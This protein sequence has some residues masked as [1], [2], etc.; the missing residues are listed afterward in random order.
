MGAAVFDGRG[1]LIEAFFAA[2]SQ[3]RRRFASGEARGVH[4]LPI[5]RPLQLFLAIKAMPPLRLHVHPDRLAK[6]AR[7]GWGRKAEP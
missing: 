6:G 2:L 1:K 7:C 5:A 4:F 3:T